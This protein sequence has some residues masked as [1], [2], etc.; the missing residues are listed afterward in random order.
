MPGLDGPSLFRH[1]EANHPELVERVAFI[2]GDTLSGEIHKFLQ[3]TRRPYLE[4]PVGP[5]DIRDLVRQIAD[6][7]RS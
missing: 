7:D 2:T 4:K 6:R 3:A 5:D 1:L